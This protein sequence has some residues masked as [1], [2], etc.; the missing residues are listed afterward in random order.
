MGDEPRGV[1][2]GDGAVEER[3]P[4]RVAEGALEAE[5]RGYAEPEEGVDAYGVGHAEA[6]AELVGALV[7]KGPGDGER[8]HVGRPDHGVAPPPPG[9]GGRDGE[10]RQRDQGQGHGRRDAQPAAGEDGPDGRDEPG[11]EKQLDAGERAGRPGAEPPPAASVGGA[12]AR[13]RPPRTGAPVLGG[14]PGGAGRR[15]A[16]P[17]PPHA[18]GF[19][20]SVSKWC[21]WVS[22]TCCWVK[23]PSTTAWNRVARAWSLASRVG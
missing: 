22:P 18:A 13:V 2:E 16:E 21:L 23:S 7:G 12:R 5:R 14:A 1:G 20:F 3:H 17:R 6:A 19:N 4:R 11:G 8:P 10:G 9:R 15:A